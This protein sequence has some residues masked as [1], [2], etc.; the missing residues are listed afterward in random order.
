MAN[1]CVYVCVCTYVHVLMC[2][3]I[4]LCMCICVCVW[5]CVHVC[6]CA[7]LWMCVSLCVCVCV[8]VCMNMCACV[9]DWVGVI[10]LQHSR[11]S[12]MDTA[13]KRKRRTKISLQVC[14]TL[15]KHRPWYT[16]TYMFLHKGEVLNCHS[17]WTVTYEAYYY[18]FYCTYSNV[19]YILWHLYVY[20]KG[21]WQL[22]IYIHSQD[23][24]RHNN[25]TD[26]LNV[27]D[28]SISYLHNSHHGNC[29]DSC[30]L[31]L[32]HCTHHHWYRSMNRDLSV[33][34]SGMVVQEYAS[35]TVC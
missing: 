22:L 26:I 5:I 35:G 21:Y 13:C 17:Y 12:V 31:W 33:E 34:Q 4:S 3:R 15:V 6:V 1:L 19:M 32:Q 10:N 14:V 20:N 11:V 18:T 8:Y 29:L 23:H 28:S 7:H 27:I 9:C 24:T 30:I 25:N 2:V 16:N